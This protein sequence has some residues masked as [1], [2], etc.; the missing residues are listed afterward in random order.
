MKNLFTLR[1]WGWITPEVQ[2]SVI[3]IFFLLQSYQTWYIHEIGLWPYP[4]EWTQVLA[5]IFEEVLFRGVILGLCLQRYT[6]RTA[7]IISSVL[8]G[9]W[10]F[11]NIVYT[12]PDLSLYQQMIYTTIFGLLLA[13]ITVRLQSLWPAV[14]LHYANNTLAPLSW[15][16]FGAYF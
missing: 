6:V 5:P 8:F 12:G 11:K 1:S 2:V 14:L 7:I 3:V 9:L 4:A 15:L 10:H 13:W 16:I